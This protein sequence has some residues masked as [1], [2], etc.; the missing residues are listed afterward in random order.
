MNYLT[1]H[2]IIIKIKYFYIINMNSLLYLFYIITFIVSILLIISGLMMTVK[3]FF[4]PGFDMVEGVVNEDSCVI[5]DNSC[6][7]GLKKTK[8]YKGL[9]CVQI[10]YQ[11]SGTTNT[12]DNVI[13]SNKYQNG[14]NIQLLVDSNAN[15]N[16]LT[17][18]DIQIY[19]PDTFINGLIMT[20][21]GL[22][23]LW[24]AWSGMN[25]NKKN[26]Y[27]NNGYRVIVY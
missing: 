24:F 26:S 22:L 10:S 18:K 15:Q 6:N 14:S 1:T 5:G 16:S 13:V 8:N 23:F 3:K 4:H 27:N 17:A 2:N 9:N 21:I 19:N 12:I 7:C 20:G 11:T 25:K